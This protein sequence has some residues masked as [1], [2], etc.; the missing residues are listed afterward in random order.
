[1]FSIFPFA[2]LINYQKHTL[3]ASLVEIFLHGQTI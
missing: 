2:W 1:M 3:T